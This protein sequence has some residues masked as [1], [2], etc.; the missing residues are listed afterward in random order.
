MTFVATNKAPGVYI[1]E[2]DV[3]GPIPG[4]GTS[5]A[6]FIGPA[7]RGPI[8]TPTFLTNW[9]QFVEAFGVQDPLDPRGP[10]IIAPP[11]YA[12]HAVRGFFDNGGA[13]CYFVRVGTAVR[14]SRTLNDRA[15]TPQPTLPTLVVT[16][17]QEGVAGN[18]ISVAVQDATGPLIKAVRKTANLLSAQGTQATLDLATDGDDF[19]PGDRVKIEQTGKPGEIAT[20]DTISDATITFRANLTDTYGSDSTI[21]IADLKDERTIRLAVAVTTALDIEPGTYVKISQADVTDEFK[22]VQSVDQ[23]NKF[24]TLTTPV[25]NDF[26]LGGAIDVNLQTVE[27]NLVIVTPGKGTET[28]SNLSMD[29]RHSRYFGKKVNSESV[30]VS[31]AGPS[32]TAPPNDLPAL[33]TALPLADGA[34]DDITQIQAPNYTNAIAALERVDD[35]NI[36]CVPDRTDQVVQ[37]AM[38]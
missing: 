36:L 35:V 3:P 28:F 27:F 2:I 17:K 9:T 34:D 7:R 19:R 4:V 24:V 26:T 30:D 6:A 5:T 22:V 1:D 11:V 29:P 38:I 31:R 23:V 21:R 25:S 16:A 33:T 15:T 8:N 37:Q 12:T 32:T 20:I 14:A 10:F 18:A 13:T